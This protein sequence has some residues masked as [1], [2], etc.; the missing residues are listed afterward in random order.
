MKRFFSLFLIHAFIISLCFSLPITLK[1]SAADIDNLTF[2]LNE[3]GKAYTV[4]D[5]NTSSTGNLVI[6]DNYNGLPVTSIGDSAFDYCTS[7]TSVTI[8]G[9][10]TTISGS[11]FYY[12]TALTS[13]TIPYGV[14]DIGSN[15]FYNCSSLINITIPD[16]VI[17]IG[18][19]V[20]TG[21]G[22]YNNSKNWE[23]SILYIGNYLIAAKDSL[24]EEYVV[25]NG[26]KSIA[27]GAF[28]DCS[29]LTSITIPY[30]VMSIGSYAF[31]YCS[32][33]ETVTI[34]KSVTSIGS[35]AFCYCT[36]LESV[37]IADG[38]ISI[39]ECAFAYCSSLANISLPDTVS[40][41]G[42]SAFN[43]TEY[44]NNNFNWTENVLYIDNH[45]I[46][47]KNVLA[48]E[49]E[50]KK[51][52]KSIAGNAF[53]NCKSLVTITIP[54][55]V[56]YIG[57][58]TFFKCTALT[59][60]IIPEGVTSI[61]A[62]AFSFC[63]YLKYVFYTGSQNDWQKIKISPTNNIRLTSAAIHYNTIEHGHSIV[64]NLPLF[65]GDE[66]SL[67]DVCPVCN[68]VNYSKKL[69]WINEYISAID[70]KNAELDTLTNMLLIDLSAV[71]DINE[72]IIEMDGYT[73]AV[74]STS[75][76]GFIGTGSIL[77]VSDTY[78][79]D[80]A[81]YTLVIRG[82]VN[83]DSV[84][85]VL[86]CMNVELCANG[87]LNTEGAYFTA[88]DLNEDGVIT[89]EDYQSVVNKAFA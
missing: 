22:Y 44:Y 30:S 65:D 86:D 70:T 41:I 37:S 87:W 69:V 53:Y 38:L 76:Y 4:T 49:Y 13:I 28:Y 88:G 29:S 26:T 24:I 59:S 60:I 27:G 18:E 33:L 20:F 64:K 55:G 82:D 12:C 83:G 40:S 72:A 66:G 3:D 78:G 19:S 75:K 47:A 89:K 74:V 16:S 50:I 5:C 45:L 61:G 57:E 79:T 81:E 14:T 52:T 71:K 32:S 11:A 77:K 25:K 35:Y 8:P 7:L 48:G 17:R 54:E 80:V 84:C 42:Y 23:K 31:Y 43:A 15:A 56:K 9:T 36:S 34:P 85:D 39:G 68:Y 1:A 58:S 62:N 51:G 46:A 63:D 73:L 21:T 6:P 10:V 67:E 2:E